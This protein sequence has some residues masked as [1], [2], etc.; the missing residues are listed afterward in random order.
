MSYITSIIVVGLYLLSTMGYGIHECSISGKKNM[1]VLF[2]ESPCKCDHSQET[3][4]K[5]SCC[6]CLT[7][8]ANYAKEYADKGVHNGNCCKTKTF[9]LSHDQVNSQYTYEYNQ[10]DMQDSN[11]MPAYM[12]AA[13]C[14]NPLYSASSFFVNKTGYP[15]GFRNVPSAALRIVAA[16]IL[17]I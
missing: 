9:A 7:G 11:S 6:M 1:I 15:S 3:I 12:F 14:A 16:S 10:D 8:Y 5:C 13:E 4:E 2:G 17:L